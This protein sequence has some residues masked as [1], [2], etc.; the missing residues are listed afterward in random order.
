MIYKVKDRRYPSKE[1][2]DIS[3]PDERYILPPS[4]GQE[5]HVQDRREGGQYPTDPAGRFGGSKGSF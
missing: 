2:F 5:A 4:K 1:T 3:R